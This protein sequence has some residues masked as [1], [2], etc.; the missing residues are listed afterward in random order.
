MQTVGRVTPTRLHNDTKTCKKARKCQVQALMSCFSARAQPKMGRVLFVDLQYEQATNDMRPKYSLKTGS[1]MASDSIE[2]EVSAAKSDIQA[3]FEIL[4]ECDISICDMGDS[5]HSTNDTLGAKNIPNSGSP[6]LGHTREAVKALKT[7]DSP[8]QFLAED[9]GSGLRAT[10]TEVNY[11]P[12]LTFNL[13]SLSRL[14][15]KVDTL[16]PGM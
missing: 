16:P 5:S 8:G 7:I 11:S 15:C 9:G 14:L 13:L 1:I 10:L 12:K 6:S 3:S 2:L 4:H